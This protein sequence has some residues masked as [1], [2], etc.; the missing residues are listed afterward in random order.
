MWFQKT[1]SLKA[2]ARGSHLI[3]NE[4]MEQISKELKQIDIGIAHIFLK[5]TS[6]AIGIN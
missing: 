1:F 4:I 2:R 6:A 3:T 5:H